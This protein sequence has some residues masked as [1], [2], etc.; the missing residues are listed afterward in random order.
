MADDRFD[1]DSTVYKKPEESMH[2]EWDDSLTPLE[3]FQ[4]AQKAFELGR[5][6]HRTV[7]SLRRFFPKTY[8]E[9]QDGF[10][11]GLLFL[12]PDAR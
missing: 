1:Q 12:P 10:S 5:Q 3:Y 4:K 7:Q 2:P 11:S 9:A 6:E 8:Q